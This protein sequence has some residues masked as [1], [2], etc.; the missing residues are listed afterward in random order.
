MRVRETAVVLSSLQARCHAC[1]K[2]T[3]CSPAGICAGNE[4]SSRPVF[5]PPAGIRSPTFAILRDAFPVFFPLLLYGPEWEHN[6][7]RKFIQNL[8]EP[9]VNRG[10]AAENSFVTRGMF[11][12]GTRPGEIT[13]GEQEE[14]DRQCAKDNL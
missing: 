10:E 14:Q 12:A 13:E 11:E 7:A 8:G 2:G 3:S 6:S 4:T 5:F 9:G 1:R